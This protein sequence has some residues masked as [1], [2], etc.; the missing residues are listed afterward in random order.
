MSTE[1]Q[2]IP[3]WLQPNDGPTLPY[4]PGKANIMDIMSST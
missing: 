2:L 4:L 3:W 1:L